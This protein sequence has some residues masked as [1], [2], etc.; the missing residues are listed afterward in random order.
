MRYNN[1]F[2]SL[3]STFKQTFVTG[4]SRLMIL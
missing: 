1:I 4:S 3:L 2:H